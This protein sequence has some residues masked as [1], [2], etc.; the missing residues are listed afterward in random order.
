MQD[1]VAGIA[2]REMT[3]LTEL[4]ELPRP[5]GFFTGQYRPNIK[6]KLAV[7]R[8]FLTLSQHL[9][10]PDISVLTSVL[11]H[12]DLHT[13]NIFIDPQNPGKITN[14]IDWQSVHLEPAFL[15][16]RAPSFLDF[17]GPK[18][19]GSEVPSLPENYESLGAEEQ[20]EARGVRDAQ[21]LFKLYEMQSLVKNNEAYR[22]SRY[23]DTLA[24]QIITLTSNILQDGEPLIKGLLMRFAREW[25]NTPA[26]K[27][28]LSCPVTYSEKEEEE[29]EAEEDEWLQGITLM[30][31]VLNA[32]GDVD[33]GWQGW[34]SQ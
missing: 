23:K 27:N 3:C 5:L 17:E 19:E 31:Q 2:N 15:H 30:K 22:A 32:L 34:V 9:I 7:L 13:E 4:K 20:A 24:T 14:I 33:T 18:L 11:W 26:G 29:Q 6:A 28:G 21:M 16:V 12:S 10:P 25:S 8:D 1:Y